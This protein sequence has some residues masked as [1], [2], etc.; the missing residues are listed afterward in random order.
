MRAIMLSV[1]SL[2]S[3]VVAQAATPPILLKDVHRI[4]CLGDSITQ[5]GEVK[6]GYVWIIKQYL[7]ALYPDQKIEVINAG[8]SGH[9]SND[10]LARL[11]K[12]VL[13][14]KPQLVTI[15]V[16][17]NDVWHGFQDNHPK[18]DGPRGILLKDFTHNVDKI[19]SKI[20][21]SGS[22]AVV[23]STTV[24]T[25]E[26]KAI[27]NKKLLDYNRALRQIAKKHNAI[28]VDLQKS[29]HKA[30]NLYYDTS[31]AHKKVLTVDGVHLNP[32]GNRFMAKSILNALG[33]TPAMRMPFKKSIE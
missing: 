13:S 29:F 27:E 9:R 26:P 12:D 31:P 28:F 19:V 14:K 20:V 11:E 2:I 16:G 10:M 22:K 7:T 15:S 24:I 33:V 17:I 3:C 8:I 32:E 25:E 4:V 30:I 6:G 23:L 21:N 1:V 5:Q 18:G